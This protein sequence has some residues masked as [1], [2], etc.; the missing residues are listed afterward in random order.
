MQIRTGHA[1]YDYYVEGV[2]YQAPTNNKSRKEKKNLN[3]K[4]EKKV[5]RDTRYATDRIN[6]RSRK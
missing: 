4:E 5:G 3:K 1:F 2:I 6:K